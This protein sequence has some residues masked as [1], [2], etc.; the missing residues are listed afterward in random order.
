M[1]TFRLE[2]FV[3]APS[4]LKKRE[5]TTLEVRYNPRNSKQVQRVRT[6]RDRAVE[7]GVDYKISRNGDALKISLSGYKGAV[8]RVL[9]PT[10]ISSTRRRSS[11]KRSSSRRRSQRGG[12]YGGFWPFTR[13]TPATDIDSAPAKKWS[14]ASMF[15]LDKKEE[16]PA[17]DGS[18]AV[19]A[20]TPAPS[21]AVPAA[22]AASVGGARRTRHRRSRRHQTRRR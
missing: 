2:N 19:P 3:A 10:Y 14:F 17:I 13:E 7:L 4:D 6:M 9:N 20:P 18:T 22:P 15:G 8:K 11:Q 12:Q 5:V 1:Q 21:P 16:A